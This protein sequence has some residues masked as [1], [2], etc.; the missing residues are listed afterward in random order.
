M[1]TEKIIDYHPANERFIETLWAQGH[2]DDSGRR[3]ALNQLYPARDWGMLAMRLVLVVGSVLMLAGVIC[4][5][6]YNWNQM[7]PLM[8]LAPIEAALVLCVGGAVYCSLGSLAGHILMVAASVFVGVLMAAFGQIYQTG[9]D[10]YQLFMNWTMLI[11]GWVVLSRSAYMWTLWAI[12]LHL[13]LFLWYN[14]IGFAFV[15]GNIFN[16]CMPMGSCLLAVMYAYFADR[17][18]VT[19]LQNELLRNVLIGLA[20]WPWIGEVLF[21]VLQLPDFNGAFG[22]LIAY[23]IVL[24]VLY[25]YYKN[26]C[27][28]VGAYAQVILIFAIIVATFVARM[29]IMIVGEDPF[30]QIV[31]L[32]VGGGMELVIF[33]FVAI[34]IKNMRKKVVAH[35]K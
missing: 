3:A 16:F 19:W 9:A 20:L 18:P 10:S 29:F 6:A 13:F 8:K 23:P 33:G 5:Y 25:R 21:I 14:Q 28:K 26:S 30:F 32:L 17:K 15:S 34:S 12:L 7:S 24:T 11:F 4:F 27:P 2:L 22:T 31:M 35:E 1:S